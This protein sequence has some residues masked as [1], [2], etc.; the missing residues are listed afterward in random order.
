MLLVLGFS[1]RPSGEGTKLG[2]LGQKEGAGT[3]ADPGVVTQHAR[4]GWEQGA[5]ARGSQVL[6]GQSRPGPSS[7]TLTSG[8]LGSLSPHLKQGLH[9]SNVP[10]SIYN[11]KPHLANL[12]QGWGQIHQWRQLRTMLMFSGQT[13]RDV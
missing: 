6:Q 3:K 8:S 5:E 11:S 4:H 7:L 13:C 12:T 9:E 2:V 10:S 1:Q